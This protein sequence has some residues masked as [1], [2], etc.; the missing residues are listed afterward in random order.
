M[1]ATIAVFFNAQVIAYDGGTPPLSGTQLIEVSVADVNDNSPVFKQSTYEIEVAEDMAVNST[2]VRVQAEDADIG[3]SGKVRY[4]FAHRTFLLHMEQFN[5]NPS[6]GELVL[7]KSLDYEGQ[8][9]LYNLDVFAQDSG[10]D[11]MPSPCKVIIHVT[12]VNDNAPTIS[13][14]GAMGPT[15]TGIVTVDEHADEGSFVAHISVSDADSGQ[16]GQTT[17][18]VQSVDFRLEKMLDK[19]YKLVTWSNIDREVRDRYELFVTCHDHGTPRQTSSAKIIVAVVDDNDHAP[20]FTSDLV[21]ITIK[22]NNRPG[23]FLTR[24]TATDRDSEANGELRYEFAM[25][26]NLSGGSIVSNDDYSSFS[27][28][29]RTGVITANIALNREEKEQY[30]L[31]VQARDQSAKPRYAMALVTVTV[32]DEDDSSPQFTMKRYDFEMYENDEPVKIVGEVIAFDADLPPYNTFTY[33]IDEQQPDG[34]V[35]KIDPDNGKITTTKSLNREEK[36]K[37][38]FQVRDLT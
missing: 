24:L 33:H 35:F 31:R 12:D 13:I 8:Y 22:E 9:R 6:T 7:K 16:N 18:G 11:S 15:E 10:T 17:C 32:V 37:Y 28:D 2:L 20:V 5:L 34:G 19:E 14:T 36:D 29:S 25:E 27:I 3:A 21:A 1:L 4:I 23:D 38:E 30:T 26:P